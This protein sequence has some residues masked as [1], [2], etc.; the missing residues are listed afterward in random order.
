MELEQA[1]KLALC[2]DAIL[3]L[4]SGASVGTTN[5]CG[6]KMLIGT[7]LAKKIYPGVSDLQQASELF[8]EENNEKG[9]DGQQELIRLLKSEF[10]CRTPLPE[11]IELA[12]IDWQRIYTTNYDDIIE[13]SCKHI[14]KSITS[15]TTSSEINHKICEDSLVCL[16]ING[17]IHAV[18]P[19]S[20]Q[21]DFKLTSISY[22]TDQF[23]TSQWGA[24]FRNDLKSFQAVIFI[25]FSMAYDLDIRRIVSKISSDKCIFIVYE[26][27]SDPN[28]KT[29]SNYGKVYP[30][31]LK[32]FVEKIVSVRKSFSP[33]H[34]FK[35]PLSNFE[36]VTVRNPLQVPSEAQILHYYINGQRTD[37][38]YYEPQER[39]YYAIARRS[40][41]DNIIQDI[42]SGVKV[43]IVHSDL[44]NGKSELL[45][46][47]CRELPSTYQKLILCDNNQKIDREIETICKDD[48]NTVVIIEDYH[49]FHDALNTF[50]LFNHNNNVTL[51]LSARTAL[52]RSY[53]PPC[54]VDPALIKAYNLNALNDEE[55]AQLIR[56]F[57]KHGFFP[58]SAKDLKR[59]ICRDC[60][61]KT[62][63]IVLSFFKNKVVS[64]K[65]SDVCQKIINP[66]Y[67]Y[68]SF[69]LFLLINKLM[70]LSLQFYDIIELLNINSIDQS[71]YTDSNIEE[72][73]N[74]SDNSF[75][76]KSSVLSTWIITNFNCL[77]D[78][79][80][81]LINA[82]KKANQGYKA[83]RQFKNFLKTV[84]SFKHL[85]F[86]LQPSK[87]PDKKSVINKFYSSIKELEYYNNKYYFWLQYAI[88]SLELHE[89]EASDLH[90]Q[91][92][93][94]YLPD[95]M[96]PYEINNQY[97]RLQ[98]KL[99]LENNY[100]YQK[101]TTIESIIKINDLLT[102]SYTKGDEEFYCYK[103]AFSYYRR[104]FAKFF[105]NMPYDEQQIMREI[106]KKKYEACNKFIASNKN[107]NI[108]NSLSK[109]KSEFL[110]L[111]LYTIQ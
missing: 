8:I 78:M 22:N 1:I 21:S 18:T 41:V 39:I 32:G 108:S 84:I 46:Q 16:H 28:I 58:K 40:A 7:E 81:V 65:F 11:H 9:L 106:A 103:M 68:Y 49:N 92:A 93:Y 34:S 26:K 101:E 20:L 94:Y 89:Y 102:F 111:S 31:G 95:E 54:T 74:I 66:S 69:I 73:V 79:I 15:V 63:A 35:I 97:A 6:G 14:G 109:F 61:K 90:F 3:F 29:L 2:G 13:K 64:N 107:P 24:M 99:M 60:Q 25:G 23:T 70:S 87:H 57:R 36:S 83:N 86:I 37:E 56:I 96:V 12:K 5:K 76:I 72:L 71:F 91:A 27:E 47:V 100:Y 62:Q 38:L 110:S 104:L 44:G 59:Y 30:I 80:D 50:D 43:I 98:M 67:K 82:T 51:I 88:S 85:K 4:G 10:I 53:Q 77:D 105:N 17:F 45:H 19:D 75:R 33:S 52:Q 55:I 42:I 48:K